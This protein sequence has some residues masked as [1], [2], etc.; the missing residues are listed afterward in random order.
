M[1]ITRFDDA[2]I[3][4]GALENTAPLGKVGAILLATDLTLEAELPR[5]LPTG[6][7]I[8]TNRVM[9][10]N[11]LTIDN[12]RAMGG[13]L[14]R[15]AGGIIPGAL[16]DAVIYGCTSGAAAIGHSEVKRLIQS[17]HPKAQVITPLSAAVAA[18]RAIGVRRLSILTPYI[19]EVNHALAAQFAAQGFAPVNV[20]GM[21][22]QSDVDAAGVSAD[23]LLKAARMHLDKSADAL[24]V[25]CTALR[26]AP[27]VGRMEKAFGIPVLSS[28]QTLAW[29]V[30]RALGCD[31]KVA[32]FGRL[33]ARQWG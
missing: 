5:M 7:G 21:N 29:A 12:L 23:A 16:M 19:A 30:L 18:C 15:A 8:Y 31:A 10:R 26:A 4:E 6:I 11:P 32:G 22:I 9:N 2:I 27:L 20:A 28:N 3:G 33:L 13:D 14:R 24:F 25:S 1:T 17:A